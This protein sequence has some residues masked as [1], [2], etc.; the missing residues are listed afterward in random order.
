M[1]PWPRDVAPRSR[2][3]SP[4]V[5][6]QAIATCAIAFGFA[7]AGRTAQGQMPV[8]RASAIAAAT[9]RG[10][11]S[12]IA[13]ADS[14]EADAALVRAKQFDNPGLGVSYTK[15]T[16]TQHYSLDIPIDAPWMRRPR[17]GSARAGLN[18]AT[19]RFVYT[20]ASLSYGTDTTYT[21]ALAIARR[22]ALSQRNTRDADSLLVL[23]RVRRDAGDASELDVQLAAVFDGQ[24]ANSAA[25]DS[26]EAVNALLALQVVMGLSGETA[27]IVLSDSLTMDAADAG[28]HTASSGAGASSSLL[29]SAAEQDLL[30]ADFS[31][32]FERRRLL[33]APS[34]AIGFESQ[35]PGGQN[36]A[37]PTIG[38]ALPLP[39]FNRNGGGILAAQ[40]AQ[41]RSAALLTLARLEINAAIAQARRALTVARTRAER[42]ARL[43]DGADNIAALS[44]LAYREGASTLLNVL[45]AQRTSRA[46]LAQYIDDLAAARNAAG[47][48]RLLTLSAATKP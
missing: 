18:A 39:I 19:S 44:L 37:L 6:R 42:S 30:A 11:R 32:Q 33:A 36:G 41:S 5:V 46:T 3:V 24:L 40:A 9:N 38:I 13:R 10:P 12:A 4:S 1:T 34:L 25:I 17:I 14:A 8:S 45:E 16:P 43:V 23:A 28:S 15:S 47:L 2:F 20:T 31:V 26:L 48:V 7:L 35:N 22:A 21:R 29:I 27:T